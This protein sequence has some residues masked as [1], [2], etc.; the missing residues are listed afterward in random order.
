M[1]NYTNEIN[2]LGSALSLDESIREVCPYCKGGSESEKSLVI[3]RDDEGLVYVC[4]R[5]SCGAKGGKKGMARATP[6]VKPKARKVFMGSTT[7]LTQDQRDTIAAK[8]GIHDPPDWYWTPACGGRVAMSVRSPKY[9]H[10]GW[11]L[12]DIYDRSSVKALTYMDEDEVSLSWYKT[13]KER[14]TVIVEDIPSAVRASAHWNAIALMGTGVGLTKAQE[15]A[16]YAVRPII[17]ALDQ[18][19]TSKSFS[20][21]HRYNSI[22]DNPQVMMLQQDM[23]DMEED[24]L[25]TLLVGGDA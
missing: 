21:V 8:W 10:R 19:A 2:L 24:M 4:H 20:I 15:I 9:L 14:P 1:N 23:K 11:V 13:N 22:W 17:V 16:Q 3:T 7:T 5:A 18:D 12:R 25:K 6:V